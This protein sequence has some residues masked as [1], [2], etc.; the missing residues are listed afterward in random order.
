MPRWIIIFDRTL[1]RDLFK[2]RSASRPEPLKAAT[3]RTPAKDIFSLSIA[4]LALIVSLTGMWFQFF[5]DTAHLKLF[6]SELTIPTLSRPVSGSNPYD[7][8]QLY[9]LGFLNDGNK[10]IM[11]TEIG[12]SLY[13]G[14]DNGPDEPPL[15]GRRLATFHMRDKASPVCP[16]PPDEVEWLA[17]IHENKKYP[18]GLIVVKPDTFYSMGNLQEAYASVSGSAISGGTASEYGVEQISNMSRFGR[19]P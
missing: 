1:Y 18:Q 9:T 13:R 17:H 11:I 19:L 16:S 10:E 2:P 14:I 8:T 15:V 12:Q 6:Q 3:E 5:R 4:L 7:F